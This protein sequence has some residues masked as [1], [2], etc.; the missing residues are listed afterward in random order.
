MRG[1]AK[2]IRIATSDFGSYRFDLR[3][4]KC[5]SSHY[6]RCRSC[7]L[8]G[9]RWGFHYAVTPEPAAGVAGYQP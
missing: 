8:P 1:Y 5:H 3:A 6:I 4:P 9:F 2:I 7:E